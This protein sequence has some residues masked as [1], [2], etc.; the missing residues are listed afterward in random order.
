MFHVVDCRG[1]VCHAGHE[2]VSIMLTTFSEA[3]IKAPKKGPRSS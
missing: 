1:H 2:N 3:A